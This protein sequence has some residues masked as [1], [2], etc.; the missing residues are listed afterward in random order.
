MTEHRKQALLALETLALSD[1]LILSDRDKELFEIAPD[2]MKQYS[3]RFTEIHDAI[4]RGFFH[5]AAKGLL[6]I[7]ERWLLRRPWSL[8]KKRLPKDT[9]ALLK[10]IIRKLVK[11]S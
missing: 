11:L 6:L 9:D 7:P 3:K 2:K 8:Q 5:C 1:G 10:R 4:N